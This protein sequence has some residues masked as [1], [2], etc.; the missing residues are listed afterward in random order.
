MPT[1]QP[2]LTAAEESQ[3]ILAWQAGDAHAL[4]PV[5]SEQMPMLKSAA[6]KASGRVPF[7][8]LLSSA[9]TGLILA[10]KKWDPAQH[11]RLVVLARWHVRNEIMLTVA[12]LGYPMSLP[13][14]SLC[15]IR[16][17]LAACDGDP[18]RAA[19]LLRQQA[20]GDRRDAVTLTE[21]RSLH[22]ALTGLTGWSADEATV[23][24]YGRAGH[25]ATA[26]RPVL[27]G[28]SRSDLSPREEAMARVW[29]S[30][31]PEHQAVLDVLA[32]ADSP[33]GDA[34]LA[35]KLKVTRGQATKRRTAAL[36]A[37]RRALPG[38]MAELAVA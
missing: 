34:G 31:P 13:A 14:R 4:D 19:A 21:A 2:Y 5:V 7:E 24:P 33:I 10:A 15:R 35:A 22:A 26:P 32:D 25:T 11:R 6:Y 12:R 29:E 9:L 36:D 27:G 38:A 3:A 37:A 20:S 30:L 17:A 23:D 1:S 8:E 18:D 16:P 28:V